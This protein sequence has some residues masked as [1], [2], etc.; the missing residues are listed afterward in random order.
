MQSLNTKIWLPVLVTWAPHMTRPPSG[1]SPETKTYFFVKP[2]L[3]APRSGPQFIKLFCPVNPTKSEKH[4]FQNFNQ[5]LGKRSK[6][7]QQRNNNNNNN[8]C[9]LEKKVTSSPSLPNII[10]FCIVVLQQLN[11]VVFVVIVHNI[12]L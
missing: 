5:Q 7:N 1:S 9:Y 10:L 11:Q 12:G 8:Y 6:L 3:A 2:F 4:H